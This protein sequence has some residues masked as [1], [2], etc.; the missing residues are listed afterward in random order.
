MN[1]MFANSAAESEDLENSRKT[2]KALLKDVHKKLGECGRQLEVVESMM[3]GAK[4]LRAELKKIEAKSGSSFIGDCEVTEWVRGPCTAPCGGGT[5]NLTREIISAPKTNPKCP[6]LKM[7]RQ[8]NSKP[9]PTDCV[10]DKWEEWSECSRA[11]GGGA[12][13]RHRAVT[14]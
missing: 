14:T 10:M 9:C 3:C 6:P 2:K 11:C 4:K 12:S 5:Q 13:S 1:V 7:T 8:C